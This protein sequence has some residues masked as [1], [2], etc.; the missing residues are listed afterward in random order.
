MSRLMLKKETLSLLTPQEKQAA[1]GGTETIYTSESVVVVFE[2]D[3]CTRYCTQRTFKA[4]VVNISLTDAP[5][6]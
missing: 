5:G 3:G 2:T 6:C 1:N 4:P